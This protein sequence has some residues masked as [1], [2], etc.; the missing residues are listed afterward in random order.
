[1][2]QNYLKVGCELWS[3]CCLRNKHQNLLALASVALAHPAKVDVA[4]T[5]LGL[6]SARRV[7]VQICAF[8]ACD[9][10]GLLGNPLSLA[11]SSEEAEEVSWLS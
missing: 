7:M 11:R 1:M 4:D 3:C 9:S 2:V 10:Y 5:H 8:A 6:P